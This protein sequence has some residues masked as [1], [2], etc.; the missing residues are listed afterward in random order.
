MTFLRVI[1]MIAENT[2]TIAKRK[3]KKY[4]PT[5]F[6]SSELDAAGCYAFGS[7]QAPDLALF[8]SCSVFGWKAEQP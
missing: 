7:R 1:T 5:C 8:L 4:M 2:P 3:K 6:L